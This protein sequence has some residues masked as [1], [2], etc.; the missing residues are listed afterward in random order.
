MGSVSGVRLRYSAIIFIAAAWSFA[1]VIDNVVDN[2]GVPTV[3]LRLAAYLHAQATPLLTVV[4]I[5]ISYFGSLTVTGGIAFVSGI[6]SWRRQQG[7]RLRA[8]VVA[9][10][11]G[12]LINFLAKYIIHRPRPFFDNP[13]LTLTT[14]SFPSGHAMASTVL[15]GLLAAFAIKTSTNPRRRVIAVSIA[16]SLIVLVCFSRIY[17]GVHYLTDVLAGVAEGIAWLVLCLTMMK[18]MQRR[19]R[20]S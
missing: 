7:E 15:Y 11:G 17:L 10:P 3:D 4:M 2:N 5:F 1:A 19:R 16:V 18:I 13:I 14:Y 20:I 9:V 6:I 12:M 8:L